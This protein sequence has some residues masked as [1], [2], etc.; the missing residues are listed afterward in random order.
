MRA[1]DARVLCSQ[2]VDGSSAHSADVQSLE[3]RRQRASG[4]EGQRGQ[5]GV[6]GKNE[7]AQQR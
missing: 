3:R 6:D 1:A 5:L 2:L 4:E 7:R